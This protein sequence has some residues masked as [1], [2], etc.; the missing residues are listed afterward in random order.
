MN[1]NTDENDTQ[2]FRLV[3][4]F[5]T[6]MQHIKFNDNSNET[7]TTAIILCAHNSLRAVSL[8]TR[9]VA[10]VTAEKSHRN[11]KRWQ[12]RDILQTLIAIALR[13]F[14]LHSMRPMG[15]IMIRRA[16]SLKA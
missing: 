2:R 11:T 15:E 4:R 13:N 14:D 16:N 1:Q 3:G 10:A 12:A 5:H 7:A 9:R 6:S 8:F